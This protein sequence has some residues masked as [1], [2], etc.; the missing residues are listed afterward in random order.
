MKSNTIYAKNG[1]Y[2]HPENL[3]L[4]NFI[5]V[6]LMVLFLALSNITPV[7]AAGTT[8]IKIDSTSAKVGDTVNVTVT[9][10]ESGTISLKYNNNVL[11]LNN[12]GGATVN[13]NIITFTGTSANISFSTI[14][15]GNGDLV[16]TSDTLTGSSTTV[17]VSG[18]NTEEETSESD[19][20]TQTETG[21]ASEGDFTIDGVAYVL[22]ERF[23]DDEIPSGFSK[24]AVEFESGTY[25]ELVSDF[26]T[27]VYLK[28]AS[29]TAGEGEFYIYN[30]DTKTVTPFT[31]LGTMDNYVIVQVADELFSEN[32][33]EASFV[34][35]EVTYT[36][37][38]VDGISNDFYFIY[39]T[40][41]SGETGWYQYDTVKKTTQRANIDVVGKASSLDESE[42]E[43]S[44][45]S[46]RGMASSLF[47]DS[48][49]KLKNTRTLLGILVFA[50]A[51]LLIIIIDILL[52]RRGDDEDDVFDELDYEDGETVDYSGTPTVSDI[53]AEAEEAEARSEKKSGRKAEKKQ[54]P[55]E[56]LEVFTLDDVLDDVEEDLS[57]QT[58]KSKSGRRLFGRKSEDIWD[59]D[60]DDNGTG[61]LPSLDNRSKL[62]K[63]VFRNT[64]SESSDI[65]DTKVDLI[66]FNDL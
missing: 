16:V 19:D 54:E 12:A 15:E 40:D 53:R 30:T 39:G 13:G 2:K 33:S 29:N 61:G 43:E 23:S 60:E 58:Q 52:F 63:Q 64:S 20:S 3:R 14:A 45:G 5:P 36:G 66:D 50:A 32:L 35:D 41:S 25:N 31:I 28:P 49:K 7:F 22:S 26:M 51:V 24:E 8:Q 34:V 6:V 10:S 55:E 4:R 47:G 46:V 21:D 18:G 27:L 38:Q 56:E 11:Q 57:A 48:L 9:G 37:Y 42:E 59:A 65:S 1:L 44:G 17:G 62:K